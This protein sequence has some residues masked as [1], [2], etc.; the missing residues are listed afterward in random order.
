MATIRLAM[1]AVS[2]GAANPTTWDENWTGLVTNYG[3]GTAGSIS[4]SGSVAGTDSISQLGVGGGGLFT[5]APVPALTVVTQDSGGVSHQSITMN[6]SW[7]TIKDIEV[8]NVDT[9]VLTVSNFVDTWVSDAADE[10]S[11]TVVVDGAKRGDIAL[12]DGND[13]VTV[14]YM[15]NESSWSNLFYVTLGNGNDSVT[16]NPE[17]FAAI[18]ATSKP[19][20]WVFNQ[21][22]QATTAIIS[23]GNGNDNV[24]LDTSGVVQLGSGNDTVGL[25]DGA[26]VVY[27]GAGT[28][29][30]N[31]SSHDLSQP[32][33]MA[34][35]TQ[36][37]SDNVYVNSGHAAISIN[38][39]AGG[40]TPLTNL[41]I[42]HDETGGGNPDLISY[43]HTDTT[44]GQFVGGDFS[45]LTLF[46]TGYSAGST[47]TLATG[48]SP[49]TELLKIQDA[50]TGGIDT[51]VLQGAGPASTAGL[52][53]YFT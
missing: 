49:G 14:N 25:I 47:A 2:P 4:F 46:L 1:S 36:R 34:F 32:A 31:I 18:A 3:S 38:D 16:V 33:T 26:H 15:S 11:R 52:H 24:S 45:A 29:L 28:D 39:S 8:T 50:L 37:D 27:L 35:S 7:N 20:G 13:N 19:A 48:P 22:P 17:S 44:T 53:L 51:L 42:S 6:A 12:G 9:N 41:F 23:V 40:T 10:A 30:V 5:V 43:G 21:T